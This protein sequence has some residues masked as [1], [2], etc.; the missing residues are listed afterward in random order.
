[1]HFKREVFPK[2][3]VK[4]VDVGCFLKSLFK[5]Y[6]NKKRKKDFENPFSKPLMQE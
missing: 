5:N 2:R 4:I 3:F 1:M 6:F